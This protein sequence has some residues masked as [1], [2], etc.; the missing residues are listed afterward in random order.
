[1]HEYRSVV[2]AEQ[3][4]GRIVT[5]RFEGIVRN[6]KEAV[7][8]FAGWTDSGGQLAQ[9]VPHERRYRCE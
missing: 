3:M 2:A 1:M 8:L 7:T 4:I 5:H 6:A 9:Q